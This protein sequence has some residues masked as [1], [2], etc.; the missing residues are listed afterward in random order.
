MRRIFA[1]L[2]LVSVA[3]AGCAADPANPNSPQSPAAV[4]AAD[5]GSKAPEA[6]AS[7]DRGSISGLVVNDEMLPVEGANVSITKP[8]VG[9]ATV[10]AAGRFTF[11]DLVPGTY[12][13]LVRALGYESVAE[14]VDVLANEVTQKTIVLRSVA[15]PVPRSEAYIEKGYLRDGFAYPMGNTTNN[16]PSQIGTQAAQQVW[17]YNVTR[18]IVSQV[19]ALRW[20]PRAPGTSGR[21]WIQIDLLLEG[22]PGT[23]GVQTSNPVFCQAMGRLHGPS[24]VV[25]RADDYQASLPD[26]GDEQLLVRARFGLA[27][28]AD[29]DTPLDWNRCQGATD[30][31]H[32]AYD[33]PVEAYTTVFYVEAA[34]ADYRPFPD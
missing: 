26:P 29:R 18:D 21:M 17:T 27:S 7:T 20:E 19:S 32:V 15:R 10:D 3:L 2:V 31:V 30:L 14:R 9:T 34:A 28:C 8:A 11:N 4:A 5:L 25:I 33:Q 24:P 22:A 12:G 1:L 13:L 16:G 23:C 6:V